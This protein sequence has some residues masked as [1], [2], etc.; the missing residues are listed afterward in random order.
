MRMLWHDCENIVARL[1]DDLN[2][3]DKNLYPLLFYDCDNDCAVAAQNRQFLQHLLHAQPFVL[4][5]DKIAMLRNHSAF[6]AKVAL[7]SN[8][9]R[10]KILLTL[11]LEFDCFV[12]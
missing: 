9:R 8:S 11:S 12:L 5:T 1:C 6:F 4:Q 10:T 3:E 2:R 7:H